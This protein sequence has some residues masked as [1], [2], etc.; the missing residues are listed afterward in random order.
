MSLHARGDCGWIFSSGWVV[1]P[2]LPQARE[3]TARACVSIAS[4]TE[5]RGAGTCSGGPMVLVDETTQKVRAF[6]IRLTIGGTIDEDRARRWNLQ[7]QA[8]MR[9]PTVVLADVRA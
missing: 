3:R 7:A 9:A 8:S 1:E 6:D 2:G 5:K 4:R